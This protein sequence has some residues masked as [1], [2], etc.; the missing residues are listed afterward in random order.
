MDMWVTLSDTVYVYVE[1]VCLCE[2]V[3]S[4]NRGPN[5]NACALIPC[6]VP[7]LGLCEWEL[8]ILAILWVLC[9]KHAN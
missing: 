9:A 2:S 1:S 5:K 4:W 3:L 8:A 6:I 7:V